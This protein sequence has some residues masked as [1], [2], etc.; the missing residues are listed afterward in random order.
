[1]HVRFISNE[2]DGGGGGGGMGIRATLIPHFRINPPILRLYSFDG[3]ILD[4]SG[5]KWAVVSGSARVTNYRDNR[6][7]HQTLLSD[8]QSAF[9]SGV[10]SAAIEFDGSLWVWGKS[11]RGQLGLRTGITEAIVP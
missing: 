3:T 4:V 1:M 2:K 11:K 5:K 8:V 9:A 6:I 7:K 10:V